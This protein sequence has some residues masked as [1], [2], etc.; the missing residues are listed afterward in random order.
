MKWIEK[1][2]PE[3]AGATWAVIGIYFAAMAAVYLLLAVAEWKI[4]KKMGEKGWKALIPVYNLYILLKRCASVKLLWQIVGPLALCAVLDIL[5]YTVP[6]TEDSW[7]FIVGGLAELGLMIWLIVSEVRLWGGVSRSFGHAGGYTA[8]LFFLTFIFEL[9]LGFGSSRYLGN[10]F[11]KKTAP[12]GN[13]E[14]KKDK[15]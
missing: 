13:A 3:F 12:A 15:K 7:Q 11:D 9:I 14:E 6:W 10:R 4:F 8:G 2:F 1:I 5:Y